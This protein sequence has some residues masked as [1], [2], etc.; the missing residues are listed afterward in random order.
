MAE[1]RRD[2]KEYI[3]V[4]G[5]VLEE[6]VLFERCACLDKEYRKEETS[7]SKGTT[8]SAYEFKVYLEDNG[9]SIGHM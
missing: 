9:D 1:P 7:R 6:V 2:G 4:R 8:E 5:N 3:L